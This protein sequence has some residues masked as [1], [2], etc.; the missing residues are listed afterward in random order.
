MDVSGHYKP[1]I[2]DLISGH[3]NMNSTIECDDQWLVDVTAQF[4]HTLGGA[5]SVV[6]V[7]VILG[8]CSTFYTFVLLTVGAAIK[9]FA[10]DQAMEDSLNRGSNLEDFGFYELG[11]FIGILVNLFL[12]GTMDPRV[13]CFCAPKYKRLDGSDARQNYGCCL[14]R[15]SENY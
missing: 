10:I 1:P 15:C 5:F 13:L 6:A 7:G 12:P 8:K 14:W 3:I 4:A 11:G 2:L 9:E